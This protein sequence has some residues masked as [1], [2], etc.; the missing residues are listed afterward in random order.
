MTYF[1]PESYG[2]NHILRRIVVNE[3]ASIIDMHQQRIPTLSLQSIALD[4][5]VQR[6][7]SFI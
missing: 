3:Y 4:V 1:S 6:L 7:D 5:I 2:A